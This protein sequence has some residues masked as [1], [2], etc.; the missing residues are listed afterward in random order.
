MV[1]S[2]MERKICHVLIDG[3]SCQAG[4]S[5]KKDR[6]QRDEQVRDPGFI[7]AHDQRMR[8]TERGSQKSEEEHSSNERDSSPQEQKWRRRYRRQA[9]DDHQNA[10]LVAGNAGLVV[11][12][13]G[14]FI[15]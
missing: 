12:I 1:F 10:E 13:G 9:T 3:V 6:R 2:G 14:I 4:E 5:A 11:L 8:G 15:A 7:A